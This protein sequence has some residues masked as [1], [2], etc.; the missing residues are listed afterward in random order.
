MQSTIV[1][2]NLFGAVALLL[3]GLSLVK[4]GV[5]RAFGARLRAGLAQGTDGSIRSFATGLVATLA[6]QSSTATALMTASFVEKGLI[7]SRMAQIVLLGANLG[8]AMTAWIVATG[9]EWLSPLVILVGVVLHRASRSNARQGLGAAFVGIGLMLLSLHLLGAATEPMRDSPALATFLAMLD[10][11]W[12]VALII[13]AG[14]AFASS[15]SLAVVMLVLS[16]SS[17]GILT[18]GLTVALVLGANLGGAIPPVM[19]T[20]ASAP[21]A[22]RVTLGNLVVR[23]IGCLIALPLTSVSVEFLQSLPLPRQNLPVDIHLA[24]NLAVAV[25]AWPFAGLLSQLMVRF[26]PDGEAEETGPRYLDVAT[27]HTPVMALSGATREV[28]RVGDLVEMMLM[29]A[30]NAFNN[31]DLSDIRDIGKF[32]KQVDQLQQE[33]KIFLSRLGR[34]GLSAEDGRRSI[35][36]IDYAINLEHMGDIIEKGLCEQI[37]K[38]VNNGLK[39]SEEGYQELKSLFNLTIDNLRVAQTIFVTRNADLA[40][41]LIE[42]K[43]NVRHME[44]RSAERHIERLRDGLVQSL[45]TSSLH[46]DMLRDL[47]RVNA[48]IASVAYPILEESGLLSESRLRPGA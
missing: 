2:V 8:T 47:K 24:F 32:E 27:L 43:V 12:P 31:N 38:K 29:R 10:S 44:K 17:A 28:L 5:T 1:M 33:V 11:A 34:D 37:A 13:S 23:A 15:S 21:S 20:L 18:V 14:L 39:F 48:H 46:L 35:V 19:A 25:L 45:Q 7:R 41:Q 16:L 22:R 40:K 30:A 3:F 26:I 4:D 42:V 9:I 6:L 36:I